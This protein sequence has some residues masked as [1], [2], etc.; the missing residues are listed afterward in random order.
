MEN[1]HKKG[2]IKMKNIYLVVLIDP[3]Y[4]SYSIDITNKTK[5]FPT[6]GKAKNYAKELN[7]EINYKGINSYENYYDVK[8]IPS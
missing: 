8:E 4:N 6:K 1:P 3:N 2:E 7:K 5:W